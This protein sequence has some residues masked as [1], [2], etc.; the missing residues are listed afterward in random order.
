ME[1]GCVVKGEEVRRSKNPVTSGTKIDALT[2][3]RIVDDSTFVT[4][5][6]NPDIKGKTANNNQSEPVAKRPKYLRSFIWSDSFNNDFFSPTARYTLSDP[7]L[8]RPP[9]E[10]FETDAMATVRNYPDLFKT[11]SPINI[12]S[13]E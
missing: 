8:L 3:K 4:G 7:P 11:T 5:V 2:R 9:L 13:F 6:G 12:D 1:T 10:E